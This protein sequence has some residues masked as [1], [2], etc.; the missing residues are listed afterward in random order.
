MIY[1]F[2]SVSFLGGRMKTL[3]YNGTIYSMR[4]ERETFDAIV[5]TENKISECIN[6][7]VN[8][9][10]YD[11]F[12]DLKGAVLFP[13]FV[14]THTHL[15]G[16]GMSLTSI[17][18][19]GET[20]AQSVLDVICE[21]TKAMDDDQFLICE[22]L[23]DNKL[24]RK[25][26]I[27]DIERVT[28]K[29]VIIKRVCRHAALV[30]RAVF[31][32]FNIT[33]DVRDIDGG[34]YEREDGKL[35]GWV[36]D[37]AM[38]VILSV[39]S[40]TDE[41]TITQAVDKAVT[42]FRSVGLTGVHTEDLAYYDDFKDVLQAYKNV[43]HNQNPFRLNILRHT[44]VIEEVLDTDFEYNEYFRSDAM[45]FYADGALGGRTALMREPYTDD[46]TTS[47]LAIYTKSELEAKVKYAREH[48]I[49][50]AVHM[51]GDKAVEMVLDAIEA[52]PIKNGRDRL[53]H[54]SFLSEDLIWRMKQLPVICDIQPMFVASDFPWALARVG[55]ERVRYSYPWHSLL[56]A[57]IICGGGS[58]SPIETYNPMYGIYAAVARQSP[59]DTQGYN[60]EEALSVY[61]AIRLYTTEAA[62]VARNED[63]YGT[64]EVEKYAD[65]TILKQDPFK[66]KI[67][68]LYEIETSCTMID[69]K[70]VYQCEG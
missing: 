57:G 44:D 42:A 59:D 28:H 47:G 68:K 9:A 3:I 14:D 4:T 2:V 61:D 58:D 11:H 21:A 34:K 50:I 63:T 55:H 35:N 24:D 19:K 69:G 6:G 41:S 62:K 43:I 13:G 15:V 8:P 18:F 70:I 25:L 30:S 37:N 32:H 36:H 16:T 7:E 52:Y 5:I 56:S 33:D 38:E 22:G 17:S 60:M 23:D 40:K 49:P 26:T 65:F 46:P 45:K 20:L 48:D 64:I 10:L 29:K 31:N 1:A 27:N 67:E 51:I 66:V 54:V 12:I 39:A 53:I